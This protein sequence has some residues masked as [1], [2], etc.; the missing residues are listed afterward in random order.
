MAEN[1]GWGRGGRSPHYFRMRGRSTEA[2][3]SLQ[4]FVF[5]PPPIFSDSTPLNA[6]IHPFFNQL[7]F[8]VPP[9]YFVVR[10]LQKWGDKKKVGEDIPKTFLLASLAKLV[11]RPLSKCDLHGWDD[12]KKYTPMWGG[13]KKKLR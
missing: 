7:I 11:V 5:P 13:V 10:P 3:P 9:L 4:S 8:Y 6:Q 2:V 12:G 1:S